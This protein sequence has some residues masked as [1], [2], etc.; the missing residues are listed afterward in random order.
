MVFDSGKIHLVRGPP[1]SV[2]ADLSSEGKP[3]LESGVQEAKVLV[4]EVVVDVE[5]LA[6][7]GAE[8]EFFLFPTTTQFEGLTGLDARESANQSVLDW[9]LFKDLQCNVLF[10][11]GSRVYVMDGSAETFGDL[12]RG[13][14]DRF[15]GP[16]SVLAEILQQ[17]SFVGQVGHKASDV[18]GLPEGATEEDSVE[19]RK[20]SADRLCVAC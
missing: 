17:D 10:G 16:F 9:I 1:A 6:Q 2:D 13:A 20:H 12:E 11:N 7:A 5:A 8:D 18:G 3:G 4:E 15:T 19:T 14:L